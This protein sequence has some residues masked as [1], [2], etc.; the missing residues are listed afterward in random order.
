MNNKWKIYKQNNNNFIK[1]NYKQQTNKLKHQNNNN[2]LNNQ[3]RLQNNQNNK[4]RHKI[5]LSSNK[6]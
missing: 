6:T 4:L 5:L 2:Y 1:N 3:F